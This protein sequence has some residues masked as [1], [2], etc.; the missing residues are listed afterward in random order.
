MGE[1]AGC[2]HSGWKTQRSVTKRHLGSLDVPAAYRAGAPATQQ[3]RHP[4]GLDGRGSGEFCVAH[5]LVGLAT[6]AYS[7]LGRGGGECTCA[8]CRET[9]GE[10]AERRR[11]VKV[12]VHHTG[13]Y[14]VK[15]SPVPSTGST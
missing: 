14:T 12:P 7:K 11:E 8:R 3:I 2:R 15:F 13:G 1:G 10:G 4:G 6:Q 9:E 5:G